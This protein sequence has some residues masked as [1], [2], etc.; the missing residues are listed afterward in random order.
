VSGPLVDY[1]VA[2]H[3]VPRR[4]GLAYDYLLA[5]DGVY[6][7]AENQ[8][9]DVRVPVARCTVRGLAAVHAAWALKHGPVPVSIW[10]SLVADATA[11]ALAGHETLLAVLHEPP[12]GYRLFRPP[13][14]VGATRVVYR[15]T[16]A[17]VLEVHSHHRM[18]AYFS[19]TDDADEQGLR[20]Y[21]VI[22]R[23]D[24]ERPEVALRVGAYGYYL[25]LPWESVFAG[26]RGAFRDIHFDP[27]PE[28]GGDGLPD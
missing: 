11:W 24:T 6:V 12:F 26:D 19:R 2:R 13:Q 21:G 25:P 8:H 17:T 5:G 10:N 22:G 7:L 1:L 27:E 3:G 18:P 15:P 14:V 28:E 23:L 4:S 9:L 16:A 20:L